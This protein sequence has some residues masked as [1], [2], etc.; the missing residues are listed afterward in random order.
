MPRRA[1]PQLAPSPPPSSNRLAQALL[2]SGLSLGR[3]FDVRCGGT[4]TSVCE[5][6]A[7][8]PEPQ[9]EPLAPMPPMRPLAVLA[10]RPTMVCAV[11]V[12][13]AAADMH[14]VGRFHGQARNPG[15]QNNPGFCTP[16][17][18]PGS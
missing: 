13:K 4:V 14:V 2:D 3:R 15:V 17:P 12:Y 18:R 11:E 6:R 7:H 10:T 1:P 9:A 16:V 5:R 8:L